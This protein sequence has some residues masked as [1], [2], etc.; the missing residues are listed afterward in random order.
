M[1][2][3]GTVGLSC[4]AEMSSFVLYRTSR[5]V[6]FRSGVEPPTEDPVILPTLFGEGYGLYGIRKSTFLLSFLAHVLAIALFLTFS[7]YLVTHRHE[8]GQQIMH[9]VTDVSPY[10]LPP[11]RTKAGG[12]G[13]GGDRDKLVASKGT[14]PKFSL[15]QLAPPAVVIRNENP[16]LPVVPTVVVPPEIHLPLPQ[17]GSLGDPLSSIIAPPSNGIGSGG[18]IGSGS[19]GGVGSGSGPGVGPGS[20]GGI[21][22]GIYRV[23][24]GVTAPQV[25]YAPDPEFSE[26]ARKAKYQGVVVLWLIVGTD[27]RPHDIRVARALGMGLDE[28]AIEAIRQW[29]FEPSRKNGSPVAVQVNVEVNFRLY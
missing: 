19:G 11:S 7:S 28:K 21:G 4:G 25:I 6:P 24:G 23:G 10:V 1:A 14:L 16:N 20:G 27:G 9:V 13:G 12:G 15:Q 22:G 3:G 5:G 18:G 2:V 29:R 8:V 17:T 26:E